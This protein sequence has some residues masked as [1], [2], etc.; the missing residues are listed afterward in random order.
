MSTLIYLKQAPQLP[1]CILMVVAYRKATA[2]HGCWLEATTSSLTTFP[3]FVDL[4]FEIQTQ[5]WEYASIPE[6]NQAI[7][8]TL[9]L[10]FNQQTENWGHAD[11]FERN[12]TAY[13]FSGELRLSPALLRGLETVMVHQSEV[14]PTLYSALWRRVSISW[15]YDLSR[16]LAQTCRLSRWTAL[17]HWKEQIRSIEE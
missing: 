3:H 7:L 12:N 11:A 1:H 15:Q 17:R 9:D 16:S 5:I 14:Y 10:S 6:C 8:H 2:R 13:F 4:P